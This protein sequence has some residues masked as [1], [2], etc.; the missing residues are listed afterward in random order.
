MHHPPKD[1]HC[2]CLSN[3]LEERS[4]SFLK[5]PVRYVVTRPRGGGGG[6]ERWRFR[7]DVRDTADR[8][9]DRL[10]E[11]F[12]AGNDETCVSVYDRKNTY[13]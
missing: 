3:G 2:Q 6:G 7:L 11:T 5:Q 4:V 10:R 8:E 13:I 9:R 1:M 12:L